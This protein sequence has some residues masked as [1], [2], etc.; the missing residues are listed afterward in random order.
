MELGASPDDILDIPPPDPG[1]GFGFGLVQ[2]YTIRTPS[3]PVT[4]LSAHRSSSGAEGGAAAIVT[5]MDAEFTGKRSGR[6]TELLHTDNLGPVPC[7]LPRHFKHLPASYSSPSPCRH[8][9]CGR[10]QRGANYRTEASASLFPAP[11]SQES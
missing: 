6:L 3:S 8:A 4:K 1:R 11:A 7:S 2:P 5:E 10:L 9:E